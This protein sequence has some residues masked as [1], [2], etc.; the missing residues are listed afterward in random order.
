MVKDAMGTEAYNQRLFQARLAKL[1]HPNIL[2][3]TLLILTN[4]Q[5]LGLKVKETTFVGTQMHL[6][7]THSKENR[8][9]SGA[10]LLIVESDGK[11]VCLSLMMLILKELVEQKSSLTH[12]R[13]VES[14]M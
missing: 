5:I 6:N 11:H 4:T 9:Q 1:G 10:T 13:L 7:T 14:L 12:N 3:D 8:N 2:K